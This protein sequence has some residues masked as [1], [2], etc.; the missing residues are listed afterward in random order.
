MEFLVLFSSS[1]A[2]EVGGSLCCSY[3]YEILT[4][5]SRSHTVWKSTLIVAIYIYKLYDLLQKL[6]DKT[7]LHCSLA[8]S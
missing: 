2:E 6:T 3:L 4:V 5:L 8:L 1:V 7:S